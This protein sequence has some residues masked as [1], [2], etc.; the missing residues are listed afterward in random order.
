MSNDQKEH[1]AILNLIGTVIGAGIFGLPII[2]AEA[3]ILGGTLAFFALLAIS[4]LIHLFMVE[5]I[6]TVKGKHNLA[7]YL[8]KTLG[9]LAYRSTI[10]VFF[11]K[12]CGTTLA[13][14][15]LGGEF[16]WEIMSHFGFGQ[17]LWFWQVLFWAIGALVV[18]MGFGFVTRVESKL[19]WLLMGVMLLTFVVLFPFFDWSQIMVFHPRAVI[20]G[21][22][23]MFFAVSGLSV[24]PDIVDIS[25]KDTKR[26]RTSVIWGTLIAGVLSWL[27]GVSIAL[28]FPG[29]KSASEIALAFP[30][31][32]WWLIPLIGLLAV[33]TSYLT[34][35][36][37]LE[38][39]LHVDAG[40]HRMT[41][42][43]V[44][45]VVPFLLFVFVSKDFLATIGFV[46]SVL[47]AS[48]SFIACL[49]ALKIF[50]KKFKRVNWLWR[51]A[52]VPVA[53]FL[54]ALVAQKIISL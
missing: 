26:A 40:L 28:G 13:Y 33:I 47:T 3:G 48:L 7:G 11:F 19:T 45:V 49:A 34:I 42:W 4:L 2:F 39:V 25:G 46:G 6:L 51:F 16:L 12:L 53:L 31:I 35:A 20:G 22:G 30:P 32:F 52:P 21:L 17:P 54:I 9:N 14:I 1:S 44:A 43:L 36:Q 38:H 10:T 50:Q 27:F 41:S 8:G 18:L 37:T 23:V 5:V 24:M 29:V 15:I